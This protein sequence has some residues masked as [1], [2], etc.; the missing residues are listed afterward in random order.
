MSDARNA[1]LRR[2]PGLPDLRSAQAQK[3]VIDDE[4]FRRT[5]TP[6]LLIAVHTE[7]ICCLNF[8]QH[9][10]GKTRGRA[11]LPR[12]CNAVMVVCLI[13]IVLRAAL[14]IRQVNGQTNAA[15]IMGFCSDSVQLALCTI[16]HPLVW[17]DTDSRR[18]SPPT[19]HCVER[20][21]ADNHCFAGLAMREREL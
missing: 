20:P 14:L 17:G 8:R 12:V 5:L 11:N 1:R 4:T 21:S 6:S 15:E 16:P 3:H 18:R 19:I 7:C 2:P 13:Q 10:Y 9:G